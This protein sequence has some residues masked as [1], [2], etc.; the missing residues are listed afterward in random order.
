MASGAKT[1]VSIFDEAAPWPS[2][3]NFQ[4][5]QGAGEMRLLSDGVWSPQAEVTAA[6]HANAFV[7]P[8]LSRL[9]HSAF[10]ENK[11]PVNVRGVGFTW[12]ARFI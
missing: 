1:S 11:P 3:H 8:D 5:F 12:F 6:P 7:F 10:D 4:P 2:L 9:K